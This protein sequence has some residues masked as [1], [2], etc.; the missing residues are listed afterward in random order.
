MAARRLIL[1]AMLFAAPAF[2]QSGLT[3]TW[4]GTYAVSIQ[5]SG[6]QNKTFSWMGNATF[7]LL[8][9]GSG[10]TG[11]IDLANF[12]FIN[13]NC[14]TNTAELTRLVFGTVNNS[15]LTL[16]VPNDPSVWAI[17]GTP[18][19]NS[20]TLSLTDPNGLTGTFTLSRNSGNPTTSF[21]GTWTG[22][23]SLTDVCP[24]GTTKKNYSGAFTMAL[25]QA[26]SNAAGVVT[27]TNVPLYDNNCAT[28][29]N[30]TQTLSVAGSV[31]GSTFT[32]AAYDPSGLFDFPIS[33]SGTTVTVSGSSTTGTAGTFTL[34][35]SSTQQPSSDFSGHFDGS[36]Q[37]SD[38][39][40]SQCVNVGAVN[41]QGAASVNLIQAGNMVSGALILE[42]TLAIVSDGF[43]NCAVL[44]GGEQVLPIYGTISNG[45]VNLTVPLGTGAVHSFAFS[46]SG[47]TISGVMQ[48]SFGDIMQFSTV[49]AA[50]PAPPSLRRRAAN[51]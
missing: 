31:D 20:M 34:T 15:L 24:N 3:G 28:I 7:V 35:Q 19:G 46:F 43:G 47:S 38:N 39:G 18:S 45:T 6:C 2:A 26:G 25:T 4:T 5:L 40:F 36:Y 13:N 44:N 16:A 50:A 37:E 29:A 9:A 27:M 22:D 32:G 41:F 8:Q 14:T 17:S 1:A 51:P 33:I 11:R 12:T 30:L 23:Y 42:D 21:T 48:D 49:K 10:V